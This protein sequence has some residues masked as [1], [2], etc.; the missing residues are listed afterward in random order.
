MVIDG[1]SAE[2]CHDRFGAGERAGCRSRF[3]HAAQTN[4]KITG[5]VVAATSCWAFVA[6]AEASMTRRISVLT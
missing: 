1:D 3:G 5:S 6:V 4:S 2:Q